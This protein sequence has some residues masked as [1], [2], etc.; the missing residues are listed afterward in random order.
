MR[1]HRRFRNVILVLLSFAA[2]PIAD[3]YPQ[4]STA[5]YTVTDLGGLPGL[6]YIESEA[7]AINDYGEILGWSNSMDSHGNIVQHAVV[8]TKDATG[9]YRI[10]DLGVRGAA[11]GINNQGDVLAG[12]CLVVPV[13]VNGNLVWYQDLNGDGINDLAIPNVGGNAINDNSQ[14]LTGY[15]VVQFDAA[16]NEIVTALPGEG[17]AINDDGQ[18]AGEADDGT[19][20]AAIWHVDGTGKLVVSDTLVLAPLAGAEWAT[21]HCIDQAGNAAG[22]S[23][24]L[25]STNPPA[26]RGRA[27]LWINGGPPIDLGAPSTSDSEALGISTVNGTLQVVGYSSNHSTARAFLWRNGKMTDLNTLASASGVTLTS[28]T[29]INSHGQIVGTAR[30]TVGKNNVEIHGFLLTP[31]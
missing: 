30:V 21:A 2:V 22:Y 28:A 18:V 23:D 20:D 10:T 19:G 14:I 9:K 11:S 31:K 16:G 1:S 13:N 12:G 4:K 29:A 15:Y 3:A 24:F 8:W 6:S 26:G 25:V 5:A 17:W 27:T 7:L